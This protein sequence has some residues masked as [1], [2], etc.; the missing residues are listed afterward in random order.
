MIGTAYRTSLLV[1]HQLT[2]ALGILLLPVALLA[3]QAGIRLP[4]RRIVKAST[5]SLESMR[6]D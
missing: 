5:E 1:L 3:R 2:V 4:I 6:S